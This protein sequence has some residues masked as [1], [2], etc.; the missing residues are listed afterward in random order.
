MMSLLEKLI[1]LL[2]RMGNEICQQHKVS[3]QVQDVGEC[4]FLALLQLGV[5]LLQLLLWLQVQTIWQA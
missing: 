3:R 5:P 1:G 2:R 4:N